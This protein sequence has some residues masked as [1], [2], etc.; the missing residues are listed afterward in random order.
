MRSRLFTASADAC[1]SFPVTTPPT[2]QR[3]LGP[4]RR[5]WEIQLRELDLFSNNLFDGFTANTIELRLSWAFRYFI[6]LG[7]SCK[8]VAGI[9]TP[10]RM[11]DR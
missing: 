9:R 8:C 11:F 1:F 7:A 6:R 2:L 3:E 4:R 10:V 5:L